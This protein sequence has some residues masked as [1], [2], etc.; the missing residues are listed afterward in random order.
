MVYSAVRYRSLHEGLITALSIGGFFIILGFVFAFTPGIANQ[1]SDFFN[2][3]TTVS[4]HLSD[5][6]TITPIAPAHPANHQ[7]FYS[8]MM[9]FFI[10]VGVLQIAILALRLAVHSRV[11]RIAESVGDLIF[12]SGAAIITNVFLLA[13]TLNGWYQFWASLLVLIGL[14]LIARFF[15][16]LI[17]RSI[18]K[19]E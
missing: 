13:G 1:T 8:A 4:Y 18:R 10:G 6:S 17:S 15:V 16:Y 12:W 19:H 5:S 14:S 3:L 11:R 7:G 2:D 9:N